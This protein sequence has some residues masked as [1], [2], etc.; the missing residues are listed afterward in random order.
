MWHVDDGAL[1]A[2]LDGALD[3]YPVAEARRVREHLESCADCRARLDEERG[4][5][6]E[7]DRILGLAA[8]RVE[9]PTFEELRAYVR[10]REPAR[11]AAS[12]RLYR[13][14]WAASV[15]LALG[16][17]WILRGGIPVQV[18]AP[19]VGSSPTSSAALDAAEEAQ[20]PAAAPSTSGASLPEADDRGLERERAPEPAAEPAAPASRRQNIAVSAQPNALTG[21]AGGTPVAQRREVAAGGGGGAPAPAALADA[22]DLDEV[23]KASLDSVSGPAVSDVVAARQAP[24]PPT[25]AAA[26]APTAERTRTDASFRDADAARRAT[27][28]QRLSSAVTAAPPLEPLAGAAQGGRAAQPSDAPADDAFG[29][30]V[31]GLD[32]LDV[33]PV[34]QGTTFA[35]MRALQRLESGD[36]LEIVHLPE[37]VAPT[38]LA[39]LR[40][41]WREL[42]LPRG[43]GW[44]VMRAPVAEPVLVELLQRLQAAR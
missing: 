15:A 26:P 4:L 19:G 30:V 34:G 14:G 6:E 43:S 22:A 28:D 32:V 20:A 10:A 25:A 7:A 12:V 41:G 9:V 42:V 44:L 5:R 33:L 31:P 40:E 21:G 3:E 27:P 16:T 2:Y 38:S 17:G 36:T 39:P 11:T 37:G 24:A 23:A 1:H 8:P 35:G 29:L 18:R 13:L